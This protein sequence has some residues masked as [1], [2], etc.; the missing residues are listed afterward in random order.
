[1]KFDNKVEKTING[2]LPIQAPIILV[3]L[4][5]GDNIYEG[6]AFLSDVKEILV[7]GEPFIEGYHLIKGNE[8]HYLDGKRTLIP[9]RSINS[10]TEFKSI[11]DVPDYEP[12]EPYA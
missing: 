2:G 5:N 4:H 3:T 1:M 9:L 10:I 11:K 7:H 12:Y 8:G 6:S